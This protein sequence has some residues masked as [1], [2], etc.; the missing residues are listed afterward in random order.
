M[1]DKKK[2][3]AQIKACSEDAAAAVEQCRNLPD[4][5]GR[6]ACNKAVR[7]AFGECVKDAWGRQDMASPQPNELGFGRHSSIIQDKKHVIAWRRHLGVRWRSSPQ[8]VAVLGKIEFHAT[9]AGVGVV[10]DRHRP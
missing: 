9:L 1:L 2:F 10:S 7:E 8:R 5:A 6:D 4:Q 3:L